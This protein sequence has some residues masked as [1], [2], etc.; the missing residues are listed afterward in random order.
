MIV[1]S[2]YGYDVS[3]PWNLNGER[4]ERHR[5]RR[6]GLE[7]DDRQRSDAELALFAVAPRPDRAVA[8]E[9]ARGPCRR[10]GQPRRSAP[11][12]V[13]ACSRWDAPAQILRPPPVV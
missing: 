10:I 11:R 1:S 6:M 13:S 9:P 8:R 12:P 4:Y 5:C 3:Q 2:S 7:V